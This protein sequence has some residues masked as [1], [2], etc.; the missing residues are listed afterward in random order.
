[1]LLTAEPKSPTK[2]KKHNKDVI[3]TQVMKHVM[4]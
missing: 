4:C 3:F 1:M 2:N